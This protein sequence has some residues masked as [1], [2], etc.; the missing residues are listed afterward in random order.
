VV[1]DGAFFVGAYSWTSSRPS[2]G[3]DETSP[4]SNQGWENTGATW[5]MSR[6][7]STRE[8]CA[9]VVTA[10]GPVG[11]AEWTN[12]TPAPMP[13][14]I[15]V[16]PNP[17]GGITT[18]RLLNPNGLEKAIEIYNATGSIVRTLELSR[19]RATLDGRHL[20]DGVYFARVAGTEAPVAK[21]IVTR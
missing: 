1:D 10:S 21:V 6:Y 5:G 19:A 4:I 20:A 13:A 9:N 15:D 14:R 16:S 17:F 8:V 7:A 3:Y 11:I 2:Y 12:P 18:I